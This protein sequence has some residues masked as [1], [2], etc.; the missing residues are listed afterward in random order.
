MKYL[1]ILLF[2][3]LVC[4]CNTVPAKALK[5]A[6]TEDQVI[7]SH[8]SLDE[9]CIIK[10]FVRNGLSIFDTAGLL[11]G[12]KASKPKAITIKGFFDHIRKQNNEEYKKG[13][14]VPADKILN[15]FFSKVQADYAIYRIIAN[16]KK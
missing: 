1:P 3:V 13:K 2:L 15:D 8:F 11:N 14:T 4:G 9:Q 6:L 10:G 5:P 7:M 16:E 12:Y